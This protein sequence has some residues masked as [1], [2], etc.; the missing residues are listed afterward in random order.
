[1][2]NDEADAFWTIFSSA[3]DF[4]G[5]GMATSADTAGLTDIRE[6]LAASGIAADVLRNADLNQD[7]SVDYKDAQLF[8]DALKSY[9]DIDDGAWMKR[10]P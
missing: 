4:N 5:D 2:D 9:Q 1:L 7:H 6:D 3:Y 10:M 8:E